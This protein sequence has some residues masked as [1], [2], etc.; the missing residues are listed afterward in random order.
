MS[1]IEGVMLAADGA[2]GTRFTLPQTTALPALASLLPLC[3]IFAHV[4]PK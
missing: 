4:P 3:L 1:V 2:L